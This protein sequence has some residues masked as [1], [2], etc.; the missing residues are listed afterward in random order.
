MDPE[1]VF[2]D[3]F[4]WHTMYLGERPDALLN[5]PDVAAVVERGRQT[6]AVAV[7][8]AAAKRLDDSRRTALLGDVLAVG[9]LG[10]SILASQTPPAMSTMIGGAT[11]TERTTPPVYE[12]FWDWCDVTAG[13]V[14]TAELQTYADE[15]LRYAGDMLGH[16]RRL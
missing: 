13:N 12:G 5:D 11:L 15:A 16:E 9:L 2:S 3:E 6:Q 1:T 4:D 8:R 14:P 7:G 10:R